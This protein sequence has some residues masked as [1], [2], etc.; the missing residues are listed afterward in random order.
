MDEK[1]LDGLTFDK[2]GKELREC[3]ELYSLSFQIRWIFSIQWEAFLPQL[4]SRK[5]QQD[6]VSLFSAVKLQ[7]RL[8]NRNFY[9][10]FARTFNLTAQRRCRDKNTQCQF[11]QCD[12]KNPTYTQCSSLKLNDC[13][14]YYLARCFWSWLSGSW[15]TDPSPVFTP[16]R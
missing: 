8:R 10:E 15:D 4:L 3:W 12:K 9:N 13:L 7:P 11:T 5:R 16:K 1:K 6:N 2:P 14:E